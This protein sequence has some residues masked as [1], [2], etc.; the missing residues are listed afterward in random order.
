M[1]AA[2]FDYGPVLRK[3][4]PPAAARWNGFPKFNFIGGHNDPKSTP[5]DGLL[6][7]A[8]TV[9]RREGV[10]LAT[11]G[12]ASGPQG[13]RGL[14]EFLAAKMKRHAG[15]VCDADEI[16]VT[17]GSMQGI[18]LVC[19]AFVAPGDSI[20]VE[21]ATYG[22]ALTRMRRGGGKPVGIPLDDG[23]MRMDLLANALEEMKRKGAPPKFIY[24]IPT[25]QNPTSSVMSADRRREMV[26]LSEAYGVPI[27]EDECYSDL[28]FEGD[29]PDAIYAMS[30]TGGVIHIGSFSKSIA[31][32]LRVGYVVAKWEILSRLLACKQDA[33]SGALEQMVL[34]EYCKTHFFDHVDRLNAALRVKRDAL[35]EALGEHFGTS[36]EFEPPRGG[37]YLWIKLPKEVDTTRLTQVAAQ[38]GV[39][40]NPGVEWSTD[41]D[42]GRVRLRICF[43]HPTVETIREGVAKLAEICGREFGVPTRI[44]NVDRAAG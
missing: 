2:T 13:Y 36:A 18:D 14:R 24:T 38:A 44:A 40:I 6:E 42:Y 12:L 32:A 20:I 39:A 3:D 35:V 43:A 5:V 8:T 21:Q 30:G 26:R 9:L 33:G 1:T 7:A 23:G 28:I 37:I 17:S 16:L 25:I 41:A 31:P 27:V 19:Q 22:G 10:N 29:R 34:A 4:L 11:Y 15:I